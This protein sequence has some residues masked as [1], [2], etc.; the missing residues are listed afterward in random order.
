MKK[1]RKRRR[2]RV[3]RV[4]YYPHHGG[5]YLYY[6]QDGQTVRKRVA[7]TEEQAAQLAAQI[8]AQLASGAPT[9]LTFEPISVPA[10]RQSYLEH[11][12]HVLGSSLATVSRYRAATQHLENFA[13]ETCPTLSAHEISIDRF[14]RYLRNLRVSPNGHP[15][16]DRRP[17]RDKG[18]RYILE[19]CRSLYAYA[20]KRRHLP[21]YAANPFAEISLERMKVED[22]KPIFVFE[23]P[24]ERAF[25]ETADDWSFPI[26]FALAKTGLR[27]G[28]LRHLLIEDVDLDAGWLTIRNKPELGWRIKTGRERSVPVIEQLGLVL[29]RVIADRTNGP[30][31]LRKLFQGRDCDLSTASYERL[32]AV[33]RARLEAAESERDRPLTRAEQARV[34]RTVWRDA[35]AVRAEAIRKSFI[36]LMQRI[37]H[38]EA[39][40]PKSW[41]HT[42]ATL[43]QDANVDPLIRQLTLGHKPTNDSRSAL[44]MTATYTHSR[45]ETRKREIERALRLWPQTLEIARRWARQEP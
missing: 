22:S 34:C 9:L 31:F 39:T 1:P 21:P 16:S 12:E 19:V 11:H 8:N 44:G 3:G 7:D 30:V 13:A 10:L 18:I 4:S 36:R 32:S 28:E 27:P 24:S 43:L 5:W 38:P 2:L 41:R 26:H 35:G 25:F 15:H 6:Q 45:H 23:Q 42:F 29:K 17:L 37:G 33:C 14:I 40:C 20:A